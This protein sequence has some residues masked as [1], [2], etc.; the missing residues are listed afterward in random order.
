MSILPLVY[1]KPGVCAAEL[2]DQ[3][4]AEEYTAL[5]ESLYVEGCFA[6]PNNGN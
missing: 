3:R 2:G 4:L 6:I 1:K 5:S